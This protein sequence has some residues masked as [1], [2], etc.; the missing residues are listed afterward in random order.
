M[1]AAVVTVSTSAA[2]GER[3]DRAGPLLAQLA[4]RL[5]AAEVHRELVPDEPEGIA[6]TLRRLCDEGGCALVL[7]SG[8]TGLSPTD[9]TPEATR[10]VLQREA[11]GIS[12]AMRL[13]SR[14][15]TPNWMLS[16]AVAGT[17]GSALVVNFPGS[18]RSIQQT[19]DA[20]APALAHALALL[21]GEQP[22]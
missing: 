7:T 1:R 4:Q 5:G 3:E 22:H 9:Q 17:R 13:A 10:A 20:L 2:A 8:G 15:H 21:A 18:P 12:E 6:A 19:A 16:R 11:P 14:E